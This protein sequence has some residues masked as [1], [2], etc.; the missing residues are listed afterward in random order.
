V[1]NESGVY[2]GSPVSGRLDSDPGLI[3]LP[4]QN[5]TLTPEVDHAARSPS[6]PGSLELRAFQ[7]LRLCSFFM[8]VNTVTGRS[9]LHNDEPIDG[10]LAYAKPINQLIRPR[11]IATRPAL[12]A[13][14][15]IAPTATAPTAKPLSP[16]PVPP[17][18]PG[19]K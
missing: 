19:K 9:L 8:V 17:R 1:H 4:R 12:K 16:L 3:S 11:L 5:D 6:L 13:P 18:R 7:A 2:G 10:Q 15:A 14:I